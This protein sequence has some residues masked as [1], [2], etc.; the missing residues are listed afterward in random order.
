MEGVQ[1]KIKVLI[2]IIQVRMVIDLAI[3]DAVFSCVHSFFLRKLAY[4]YDTL[5]EGY[6]TCPS[7]SC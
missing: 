4:V 5:M 1:T 6:R 7:W 3:D 2:N